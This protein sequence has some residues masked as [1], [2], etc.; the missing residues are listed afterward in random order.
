MYV[1]IDLYVCM[2]WQIMRERKSYS[3][4]FCGPKK[5][6]FSEIKLSSA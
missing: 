4:V 1:G 3:G 6:R 5:G 2:G